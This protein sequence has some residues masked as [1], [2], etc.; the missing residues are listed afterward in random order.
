MKKA[1]RQNK[2]EIKGYRLDARQ[3]VG[4]FIM[5]DQYRKKRLLSAPEQ[6]DEEADQSGFEQVGHKN[7][8]CP[9][10]KQGQ[11]RR[12]RGYS[13]SDACGQ[14]QLTPIRGGLTVFSGQQSNTSRNPMMRG[15]RSASA[16]TE[17][18][19]GVSFLVTASLHCQ[20]S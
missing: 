4:F 14:T 11:K 8:G 9:C 2:R 6:N 18:I 19:H 3:H 20:S 10:Q 13:Q 15:R 16:K 12:E 5:T 1:Y 17:N 7:V